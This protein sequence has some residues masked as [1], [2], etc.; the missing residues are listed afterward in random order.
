MQC[1]SENA[2]LKGTSEREPNEL[3]RRQR[4]VENEHPGDP[5]GYVPGHR[6]PFVLVVK[7]FEFREPGYVWEDDA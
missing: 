5:A 7:I 4:I 1:L 6:V 3:D 2:D